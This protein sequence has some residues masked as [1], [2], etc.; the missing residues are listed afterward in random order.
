MTS[1]SSIDWS[2]KAKYLRVTIDRNLNF[3]IHAQNMIYK[4]KPALY[5]VLNKNSQIP[6]ENNLTIFKIY[7]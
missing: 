5:L 4:A 3:H 1:G 6:A 7:I 2:K